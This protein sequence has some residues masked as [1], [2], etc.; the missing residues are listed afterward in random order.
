MLSK[1][2]FGHNFNNPYSLKKNPTRVKLHLKLPLQVFSSKSLCTNKHTKSSYFKHKCNTLYI[3]FCKFLI[4]GCTMKYF[5]KAY[6]VVIIK[7]IPH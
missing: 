7:P 1:K 5:Q 4:Q 3:L 6:D 2:I